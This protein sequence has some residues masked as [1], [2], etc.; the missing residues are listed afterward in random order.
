M[1]ISI[2]KTHFHK[3]AFD[4]KYDLGVLDYCR[5]LKS[6]YSWKEFSFSN[7]KWRF[8][9]PEI[10]VDIKDK[11]PRAVLD[12]ESQM[13]YEMI[14]SL[15]GREI[16]VEVIVKNVPVKTTTD[17]KAEGVKTTLRPYQQV[18]VE[19]FVKNGGRG[20]LSD[21]VGS[22]KSL[23]TLAYIA[24]T[25]KKKCLV[26]CPASVKWSWDGEVEKHTYMKSVV[27]DS[28]SLPKKM[29]GKEEIVIINYDILG[30]FIET[31]NTVKWDVL[32][33]DEQHYCKSTTAKRTKYVKAISKDI[34]SIICLSATPVLSRPIEMFTALNILDP[35]VWNN[36]YS[37]AKEY[38]GLKKTPW[39]IEAKGATNLD[40]LQVRTSKY[41]L[42]RR[43]E[44]ILKDLPEQIYIDYPVQL[45]K[46]IKKEYNLAE[47]E[48]A[49]Y[50]KK[51]KHK[52][53]KDIQK[54]MQ[55][56]KLVKLG[57]LR[58]L[59]TNGKIKATEELINN[60]LESGEKII[61]FSCYNEP[62]DYLHEKFKKES[63]ILTGKS[64]EDEKRHAVDSFQN[65]KGIRIFFGGMKSAG[66][67]ITLTASSN[68]VFMDYSWVPADHEQ[69]AGRQ[70]RIGNK[71][72]SVNIYQL[73][74]K[75]TI[76]S[77]MKD[78]LSKKSAVVN[79]LVDNVDNKKSEKNL[80]KDLLN[81]IQ[82]KYEIHGR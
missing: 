45:D 36:W 37:Y 21:Q 53:D 46:V 59:T 22:G 80:I 41:F 70:H 4:F 81:N 57:E 1:N 39:G 72:Q 60:I 8:I 62:L 34:P 77:F 3:Y 5:F 51:M 65:K 50:L 33:L 30:K 35:L 48:F 40:D 19:F 78:L 25:K 76:D 9:K 14:L 38:C 42:R 23:Q 49:V 52:K 82:E 63:V 6:R 43:K 17:F 16:P 13:D 26:V 61:V 47:E 10:L 68:V 69:A 58:T 66:V 79:K 74:A 56:E 73:F 11:Y 18:G 20:Y 31:I 64:S 7:K 67:G 32:V 28:K 15:M 44:D 24:H 29:L 27:I 55:A 12:N 75:G 54:I 71:A 2:D